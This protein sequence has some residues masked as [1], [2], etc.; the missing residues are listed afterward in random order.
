MPSFCRCAYE[1][2]L[3]LFDET[4]LDQLTVDG[5]GYGRLLQLINA[6][7]LAGTGAPTPAMGC[8]PGRFILLGLPGSLARRHLARREGHCS[9]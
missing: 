8:I 5:T 3:Q 4:V 2:A 7:R 6:A 9:V 1:R